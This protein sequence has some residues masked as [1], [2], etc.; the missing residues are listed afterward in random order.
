[1]RVYMYIRWREKDGQ[2]F[3]SLYKF[4]FNNS[5]YDY[6]GRPRCAIRLMCCFSL[7]ARYQ[8]EL[9]AM[10]IYKYVIE[11]GGGLIVCEFFKSVAF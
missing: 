5:W 7:F 1:M 8:S 2:C 10:L 4:N 9:F 11:R 6:T 3:N